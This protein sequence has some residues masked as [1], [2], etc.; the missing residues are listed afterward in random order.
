[1]GS[2]K[3]GAHMHC[4]DAQILNMFTQ[5]VLKVGLKV[6]HYSTLNVVER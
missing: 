5:G 4:I 3:G 6:L 1:M 2:V